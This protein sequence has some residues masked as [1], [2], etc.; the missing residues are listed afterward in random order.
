MA[1]PF[2]TD[3]QATQKI[4]E[5][6]ND[7]VNS[8]GTGFQGTIKIADTP[9]EE[10][11]YIPTEAG[12]YTNAG[13]LTYDPEDKDK[14]CLVQFIYD[15]TDWVKN[16]VDININEVAEAYANLSVNSADLEIGGIGTSN[17]ANSGWNNI[18]IRFKDNLSIENGSY[19]ITCSAGYH[20]SRVFRYLDGVFV[21]VVLNNA[22]FTI[23]TDIANEIRL[24]FAK[25]NESEVITNEDLEAFAFNIIGLNFNKFETLYDKI[26]ELE[27]EVDN[28]TWFSGKIYDAIGDSITFG[29]IPRNYPGY[30]G[31]LNSWAKQSA[32]LLNMT[33]VNHG[34]SGSTLGQVS[35]TDTT[36]RSP[37]IYRISDLNA[38][39]KLVTFMGGTND[40]RNISVLGTMD[41]RIGWTYYGAL[42]LMCQG[43]LNKYIYSQDLTLGKDMLIVGVTPIQ[44]F[45][46]NTYGGFKIKDYVDA[47][48]EVCA[49]YSIPCFDAWS[50]SGLTPNEFRT[51]QGTESN[52]T[53]MYN[54][55][56]T[57]GTH[58]T[59]EGNAIWAQRFVGF[60]KTLIAN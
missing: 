51:L 16:R 38:N 55:L 1:H 22:N 14:G 26:K 58:P 59:N 60:L 44:L 54:P 50:H 10:G 24:V 2:I 57:D 19:S 8:I 36:S 52:Y 5:S 6:Y 18:R 43:L 30:P 31:Q 29:F 20:I 56:I 33:F 39:A 48:K 49:Y 4:Q 34:I 40:L 47:F 23:D 27:A 25:T 46:D 3:A 42:H 9:T 7:I 45:P 13:G 11:V 53:D 41:D 15:G 37:M 28:T 35:E 17:G 32:E 21:D 12:T